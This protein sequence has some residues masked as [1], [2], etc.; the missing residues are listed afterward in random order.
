MDTRIPKDIFVNS[1]NGYEVCVQSMI[2]DIN[3]LLE[4]LY[5]YV[6]GYSVVD[7]NKLFVN[8]LETIKYGVAEY[9]KPEYIKELYGGGEYLFVEEMLRKAVLLFY[10]VVK[11]KAKVNGKIS[12]DIRYCIIAAYNSLL[13]LTNGL[14]IGMVDYPNKICNVFEN[15]LFLGSVKYLDM[16]VNKLFER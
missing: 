12:K 7:R 9:G 8:K 14:V 6:D 5:S 11:E 10:T 1:G 13:Y 15:E 3:F 2:N 16:K 4:G